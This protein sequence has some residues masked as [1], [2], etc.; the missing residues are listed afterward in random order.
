MVGPVQNV[1]RLPRVACTPKAFH[2][3]S[4]GFVG[5]ADEPWVPGTRVARTLKEFHSRPDAEIRRS[6]KFG[7]VQPLRGWR[8]VWTTDP[9]FRGSAAEPW[10]LTVQRPRRRCQVGVN[11]T[12]ARGY[13]TSAPFKAQRAEIP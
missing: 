7:R 6:A 13:A 8:V 10:A 9:G 5:S 12:S 2:C 4:P 3:Q 1:E 11:S